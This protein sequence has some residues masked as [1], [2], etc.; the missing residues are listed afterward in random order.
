MFGV[1]ERRIAGHVEESVAVMTSPY[2]RTVQ[3]EE[4]AGYVY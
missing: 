2:Y 3:W 4:S 1:H